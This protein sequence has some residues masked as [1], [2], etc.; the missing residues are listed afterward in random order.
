V[1]PHGFTVSFS[2]WHEEFQDEQEAIDCFGFGLSERCRLKVLQRGRMSYKWVVQSRTD[3][4]WTSDS[5]TGLIF[6]PFW[7][8]KR[9]RHLQNHVVKIEEKPEAIVRALKR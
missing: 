3:Q 4:G 2:G 8:P 6:F 5:E 1:H 9:E 7:L